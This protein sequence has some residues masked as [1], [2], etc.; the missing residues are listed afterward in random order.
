MNRQVLPIGQDAGRILRTA[1]I[2]MVYG[3]VWQT[4]SAAFQERRRRLWGNVGVQ[5]KQ[6]LLVYCMILGNTVTVFRL[7][8]TVKIRAWI[9]G[10]KER[11]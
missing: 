7:D 2:C 8:S 10:R 11:G 4:I 3:M 9:T 5:R 1:Q 6:R